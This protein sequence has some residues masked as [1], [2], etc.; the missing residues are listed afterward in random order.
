MKYLSVFDK[1]IQKV[2]GDP[3]ARE[4]LSEL[5]EQADHWLYVQDGHSKHGLLKAI[6]EFF[7]SVGIDVP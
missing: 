5:L 4:K 6:K 2:E 3:V 7:L 1:A